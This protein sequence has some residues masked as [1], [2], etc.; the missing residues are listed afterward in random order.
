VVISTLGV[1]WN[2][3]TLMRRLF[4]FQDDVAAGFVK[5][6]IFPLS[7]QGRGQT[8]T[9]TSRGSFMQRTKTSSLTR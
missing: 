7:A 2:G 1:I 4:R 5:P 9:E 6:A 3:N 8:L